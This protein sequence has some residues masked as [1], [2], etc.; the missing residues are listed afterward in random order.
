M[1]DMD[2][3]VIAAHA[4]DAELGCGGT[5]LKLNSQGCRGVIVDMTSATAATLGNAE[6]RIQ[7]AQKAADILGVEERVNLR[8]R[9]A[10]LKCDEAH[11]L[12]VIEVIRKYRPKILI[13]QYFDDYHPDHYTTAEIVKS[14][15]YK[16]GLRSL[17]PDQE[18]YRPERL[19]HFMGPVFFEPTFCVDISEFYEKK[20]EA[21]YAYETQFHY[22]GKKVEDAKTQIASPAFIEFVQTRNRDLGTRIR[23]DYAEGFYCRE[24]AE[25][26][27]ICNLGGKAY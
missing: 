26:D 16:S 18:A 17:L 19:F 7:E 1:F 5:I 27:N 15:W 22:P 14:A 12:K 25:V 8:L 13:T 3:M 23:R 6:T 11:V 24:L 2:Y 20:M 9:D 4:D 21:V 10:H